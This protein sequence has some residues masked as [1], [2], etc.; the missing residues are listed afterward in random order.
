MSRKQKQTMNMIEGS[1]GDKILRFAVPL[2]ITGIL[3]Q[4]FNATD[5]AVVGQFA[6]KNAKIGRAHV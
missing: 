6:G 5:V 3:Q 4:I 2:A 1:L